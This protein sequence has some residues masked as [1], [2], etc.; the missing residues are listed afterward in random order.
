MSTY[1]K[2]INLEK[3]VPLTELKK[4]EAKEKLDKQHKE[5]S[6]LVTG[7]FKNL[8]CPGG[9]LEF[10][11]RKFPQDPIRI[12]TFED[13]KS[14]EVPLAVAKHINKTCNEKRHK[15]IIDKDG[16]K[17]VDV[18]PNRQRYQFLSV[19]FME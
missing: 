7:V 17:T 15:Y 9:G 14:Y 12:Y 2:E 18:L 1:V 10:P 16:N 13:G 6:R 3:R 4:K 5:E 8:E 19:D 11:F